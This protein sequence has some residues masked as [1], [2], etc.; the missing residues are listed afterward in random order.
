MCAEA[1]NY[2]DCLGAVHKTVVIEYTLDIWKR[3]ILK[4]S[5]IPTFVNAIMTCHFLYKVKPLLC[6]SYS[7]KYLSSIL[8]GRVEVAGT[9][10]LMYPRQAS[11]S[12][13]QTSF[14]Q[15]L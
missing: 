12:D 15:N 13:L 5:K 4:F 1:W 6:M 7:P 2:I 3:C 11:Q 14:K 8:G 10:G 9:Q